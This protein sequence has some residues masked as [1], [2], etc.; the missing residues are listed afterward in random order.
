MCWWLKIVG[1]GILVFVL[2]LAAQAQEVSREKIKGLDEQVQEI[3][4]DVLAIAAEL[5]QLEEK[6]LYPSNTEVAIF[7]SL[8][9]GETFRLFY[10]HDQAPVILRERTDCILSLCGMWDDKSPLPPFRKGGLMNQQ[11]QVPLY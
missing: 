4:S 5:K 11:P 1:L 2:S 8:A 3:K 6:L 7:I 10:F 9:G